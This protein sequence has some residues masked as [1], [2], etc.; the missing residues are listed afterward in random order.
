M[1]TFR[2]VTGQYWDAAITDESYGTHRLIFAVRAGGEL[3]ARELE[4]HN[5]FEAEQM[6]LRLSDGE[7]RALLE[8]ASAW[9]PG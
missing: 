2:D 5:R 7:L 9:Q 1:R 8:T 6:L 3:R 4:H